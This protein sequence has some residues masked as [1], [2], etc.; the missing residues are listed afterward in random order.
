MRKRE[1]NV[2]PKH[3]TFLGT[4]TSLSVLKTDDWV[5]QSKLNFLRDKKLLYL[6][7][8]AC[9]RELFVWVNSL[10]VCLTIPSTYFPRLYLPIRFSMVSFGVFADKKSQAPNNAPSS[11]P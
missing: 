8:A 2:K 5:L 11:P 9:E 3:L 10:T 1:L 7:A 6:K 4:H